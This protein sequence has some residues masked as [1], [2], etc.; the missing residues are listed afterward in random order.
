MSERIASV[1]GKSLD[2][3]VRQHF[4]R[5]YEAMWRDLEFSIAQ[6]KSGTRR[7][8][9]K[10]WTRERLRAVSVLSAFARTVLG[11]LAAAMGRRKGYPLGISRPIRYG[12]VVTVS[13]A[14]NEPVQRA[15]EAFDDLCVSTGVKPRWLYAN[16]ISDIVY[17]INKEEDGEAQT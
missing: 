8:I 2:W 13:K 15:L 12:S 5:A 16:R 6:G 9:A 3:E 14:T 11:P 7:A 1:L 4:V 17:Y 10:G